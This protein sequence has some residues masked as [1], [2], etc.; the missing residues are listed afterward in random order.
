MCTIQIQHPDCKFIVE[1]VFVIIVVVFRLLYIPTLK[2]SSNKDNAISKNNTK[3]NILLK[4]F[5]N[6]LRRVIGYNKVN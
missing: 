1:M 2:V 6:K 5:I 3:V 4:G